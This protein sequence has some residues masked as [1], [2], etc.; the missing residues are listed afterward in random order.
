[1]VFYSSLLFCLIFG[2]TS[3]IFCFFKHVHAGPGVCSDP[4][5]ETIKCQVL[6]TIESCILDDSNPWKTPNR[7][8]IYK[9]IST[10]YSVNDKFILTRSVKAVGEGDFK[11]AF[12]GSHKKKKSNEHQNLI[13]KYW[14]QDISN[15]KNHKIK[16]VQ[17]HHVEELLQ[18][19]QW[20][21]ATSELFCE[22]ESYKNYIWTQPIIDSCPRDDVQSPDIVFIEPEVAFVRKCPQER[23]DSWFTFNEGI[24]DKFGF[25]GIDEQCFDFHNFGDGFKFI[26]IMTDTSVSAPRDPKKWEVFSKKFKNECK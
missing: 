3:G 12:K 1:M 22:G 18:H 23:V 16:T 19:A 8:P 2:F 4:D 26:S 17:P 7:T 6:K 15:D 21:I 13:M 25:K 10:G 20:A 14:I 5:Y 9:Y 11:I 24:L